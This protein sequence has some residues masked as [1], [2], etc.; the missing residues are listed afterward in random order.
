MANQKNNTTLLTI[1]AVAL[2][3]IAGILVYK[4]FIEKTPEEKMA[5]SISETINN[6]GDSVNKGL[7]GN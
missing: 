7:G 3:A 1:I 5:D 2:V 4:N 6:I